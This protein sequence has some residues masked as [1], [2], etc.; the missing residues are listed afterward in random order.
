MK[1]DSPFAE[2]IRRDGFAYRQLESRI[3][4]AAAIARQNQVTPTEV[5]LGLE[6]ANI[7]FS[8]VCREAAAHGTATPAQIKTMI[9]ADLSELTFQGLTIR[10]MH[11]KG[12]R[13]GASFPA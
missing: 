1:A 5:W 4:E 6:E 3:I 7:I 13:V 12:I 2:S 10:R 11:E 8:E 9:Y